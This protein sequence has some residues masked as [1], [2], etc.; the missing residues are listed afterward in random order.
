MAEQ[1]R[2]PTAHEV[3]VFAPIDVAR[4]AAL[5]GG[6]ELRIAF[7]KA[8][9]STRDGR[10][11]EHQGRRLHR[12]R[13]RRDRLPAGP[14]PPPRED[15]FRGHPRLR[16]RTPG[17]VLRAS[18]S[19]SAA[20]SPRSPPRSAPVSRAR[21]SARAELAAT[22]FSGVTT[23][24][25]DTAAGT[26]SALAERTSGIADDVREL[27]EPV[28]GEARVRVEPLV[29]QLQA[30]PEHVVRAVDAGQQVLLDPASAPGPAPGHR[31]L[32]RARLVPAP[33]HRRVRSAPMYVAL[34]GGVGAAV[35]CAASC[36]SFLKPR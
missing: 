9:R 29:E 19:R 30:V 20:R 10:H 23:T 7:G 22:G 32:R 3:D 4:T 14:G 35:S 12:R 21:P 6:K 11:Q 25:T 31:G 17:A 16:P 5:R 26:A 33:V 8:R 2:P 18:W 36:G 34:A 15:Q 27:V 13:R 28:V 1:D 24:I